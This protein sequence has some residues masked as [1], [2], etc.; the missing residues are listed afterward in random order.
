MPQKLIYVRTLVSLLGS[1][2]LLVGRP[3]SLDFADLPRAVL[4]AWPLA[5]GAFGLHRLYPFA[6]LPEVE[7][8]PR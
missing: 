5:V 7:L 4:A 6:P 3:E 1:V 8:I 2:T